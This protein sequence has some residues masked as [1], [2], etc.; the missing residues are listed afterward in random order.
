MIV[1]M[2]SFNETSY[3][4]GAG[5]GP[6][7]VGGKK[8]GTQD[9]GI[10]IPDSNI[11]KY[12]EIFMKLCPPRNGKPQADV[13]E[14]DVINKIYEVLSKDDFEKD[15][16][17]EFLRALKNNCSRYPN[18][19]IELALILVA[20]QNKNIAPVIFKGWLNLAKDEA[21]AA[22]FNNWGIQY[23]YQNYYKKKEIKDKNVEADFTLLF[24]TIF[25][26]NLTELSTPQ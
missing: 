23:M 24:R 2:L 16:I 10:S 15:E 25:Q 13:N 21:Y 3:S 8:T 6:D 20:R 22:D 11:A 4:Q 5:S 19:D 17:R 12:N 18:I 7:V 1:V 26:K 9:K 14:S